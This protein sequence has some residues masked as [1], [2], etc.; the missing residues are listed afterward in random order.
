MQHHTPNIF[1]NYISQLDALLPEDLSITP[2]HPPQHIISSHPDNHLCYALYFE[3]AIID[4]KLHLY[5]TYS[6]N[7]IQ[8]SDI[9]TLMNAIEKD[10]IAL[11]SKNY[12]AKVNDVS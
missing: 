8:S 10:V 12:D 2:I 7:M 6:P 9:D 3:A 4:K 1:F 5:C 11:A